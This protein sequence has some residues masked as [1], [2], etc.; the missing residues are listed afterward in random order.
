MLVVLE[1]CVRNNCSIGLVCYNYDSWLVS[2]DGVCGRSCGWV[3]LVLF[4]FA[5]CLVQIWITLWVCYGGIG[6]VGC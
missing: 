5:G 3:V 2:L 6:L 4:Y 1:V